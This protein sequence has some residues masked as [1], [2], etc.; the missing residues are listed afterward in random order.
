MAGSKRLRC[1]NEFQTIAGSPKKDRHKKKES[2]E[3]YP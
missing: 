3:L 2:K 1:V